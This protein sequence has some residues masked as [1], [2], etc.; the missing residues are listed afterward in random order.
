MNGDDREK[1]HA[2]TPDAIEGSK[3]LRT[4]ENPSRPLSSHET[5]AQGTPDRIVDPTRQGGSNTGPKQ[6]TAGAAPLS[7]DEALAYRNSILWRQLMGRPERAVEVLAAEVE[8]L[9]EVVSM[10]ESARLGLIQLLNK[11]EAGYAELNANMETLRLVG[12]ECANM[13]TER[14]LRIA[15]YIVALPEIIGCAQGDERTCTRDERGW[16][17]CCR[18]RLA[19][20]KHGLIPAPERVKQEEDSA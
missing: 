17:P 4:P 18:A 8:R 5:A 6:G 7:V 10:R 16:Y 9:R 1:C 2:V 20:V 11:A 13:L 19:A 15:G 14:N 3:G 12:S